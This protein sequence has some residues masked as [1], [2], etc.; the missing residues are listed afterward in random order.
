MQGEVCAQK[1]I[2]PQAQGPCGLVDKA[3]LTNITACISDGT[4]LSRFRD[5]VAKRARQ[6]T[7]F[8]F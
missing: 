6:R 4:N 1:G 8:N 7:S 5:V 2:S 3:E